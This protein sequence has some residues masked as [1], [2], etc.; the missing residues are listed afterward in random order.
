[1]MHVHARFE[2]LRVA[3][4]LVAFARERIE[5]FLH[6]RRRE[7]RHVVTV[8]ETRRD[9]GRTCCTLP[10]D[11]ESHLRILGLRAADCAGY[12]I[13]RAAE[14]RGR[15]VPERTDDRQ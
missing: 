8:R 15:F 13:V 2:L 10:A 14:R 12:T 9:T 5:T 4:A 3:F 7:I 6:G 11:P 1:E